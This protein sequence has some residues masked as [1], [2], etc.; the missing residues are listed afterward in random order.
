MSLVSL[1]DLLFF[2]QQMLFPLRYNRFASFSRTSRR[3]H[4][5][6]CRERN[7]QKGSEI[8]QWLRSD[9]VDVYLAGVL[10]N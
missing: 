9:H 4:Y 6:R 3:G 10:F 7:E 2:E 8:L 1:K 5:F